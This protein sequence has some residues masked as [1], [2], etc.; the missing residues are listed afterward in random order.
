MKL[1]GKIVLFTVL[2]CV[3]SILSVFIINYE[4]S[5]KKLE[6]ETNK[7]VQLEAVNIAKDI[8]KWMSVQ[9]NT[10]CDVAEDI[11]FNDN[12]EDDYLHDY[13]VKANERYPERDH[14]MIFS[15]G[16]YVDVIGWEPDMDLTVQDWY[17]EAIK[18]DKVYVSEPFFNEAL[19]KMTITMSKSFKTQDGEEGVVACDIV[20]DHLVDLVSS[21]K[22]GK[23]SYAFLIDKEGNIVTHK[24][25]QFKPSAE[26]ITNINDM[27]GGKLG[28]IV[29]KGK[30]DIR[31][32]KIKDYDKAYR[33]FFFG[34]V[35]ESGW[36][37]GV[38]VSEDYAVG[39]I[40]NAIHYTIL[41]TIIVLVVATILSIYISNSITKPIVHSVGIAE[42][43]ANLNL[44]D[45]I[46]K[47]ELER[48]DE[49][50]QVYNSY[51]NIIE[52]LKIFMK[53]MENSIRTNRQVYEETIE[54]LNFLTSQAEDTSATTEELS[55]GME[56]T[57]SSTISLDES[58]SEINKAI[59]DFAEK[60]EE[61]ATTS[62][63]I[64]TKAD[65]LSSQFNQ[66]K[67]NTMEIYT[68]TRKEIEQAIESSKE[69][70]K[71]NVLSSAILEITE[72]T[73]LLS[74]NAAIEAARA[75]ESGRGFAVVAE[76][77]RKLAENSNETVVEIQNVTEGIIKTV[78]QLVNNTT[79][80]INFL[81]TDIIKDYEMMVETVNQYK[82]DGSSLNNIISDLSA[83][84]EELSATI[85][86]MSESMKDIATTVE[87]STTATNNIAEKNMNIV[88][89]IN[90]INNIMEKNKKVS[91]KL[92]EIVSQVKF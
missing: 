47:K 33:F 27:L 6:E 92:E 74:L 14:F 24:N 64:S 89:A 72:Q 25:D 57:A 68:T 30:M 82:D 67:D 39:A 11:V 48:K 16:R 2:I 20:L 50:G 87:E 78:A 8:D 18:S 1:K 56:E 23:G 54:R 49:V 34:D 44:L 51:Q 79:S 53:E 77:I 43:I 19:S 90:N 76:E 46:D 4:V 73:S 40:D 81:E 15:D 41:A 10:L 7:E 5:I 71:I 3:V 9:K 21:A 29:D 69:V 32:R 86:Q 84:S 70:D 12:L 83:T 91:E 61:G 60:V 52:K 55:A 75:G 62:S 31:D 38:G 58:A 65:R 13:L 36:K 42:N 85:N 28:K 26:K 59:S 80:L 63:E 35:L 37:V 88:E 22:I 45:E 17:K 66:A